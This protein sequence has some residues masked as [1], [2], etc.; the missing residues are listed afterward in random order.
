MALSS[1][2]S[3]EGLTEMLTGLSDVQQNAS[4]KMAQW[5]GELGVFCHEKYLENLAGMEP[6]T[7]DNPLPVGVRSGDLFMGAE[8]HMLNQYSFE[9]INN[10]PYSGFIEDGTVKMAPRMP[11]QNAVDQLT[12]KMGAEQDQVLVE[13]LEG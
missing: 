12:E 1:S 9:E 3:Y 13:I 4:A 7:A 11:L 2:V 10:T 6:S 5:T 8:L